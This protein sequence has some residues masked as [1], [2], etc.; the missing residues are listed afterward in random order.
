MTHPETTLVELPFIQ[1]LQSLGW[2]YLPGDTQVPDFTERASFRQVLLS[3]RLRAA[4][5][6]INL[7]EN[8]QPWLDEARISEA[9]NRLERLGQPHLI[10]ANQAATELLLKGTQ[11][12]RAGGRQARHHPLPRFRAPGAQRLPRHQPVP[13][14][15]ALGRAGAGLHRARQGRLGHR[16]HQVRVSTHRNI[17]FLFTSRGCALDD[18]NTCVELLRETRLRAEFVVALGESCAVGGFVVTGVR[19]HALQRGVGERR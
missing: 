16:P 2:D 9:V 11:V 15:S 1:Q 10:E 3:G 18:V 5:R 14:G 19:S 7:D 12:R 6:R 17:V 13:R 4:L 8:G